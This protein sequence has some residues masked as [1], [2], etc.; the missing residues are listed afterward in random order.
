M[1][2]AKWA[3]RCLCVFFLPPRFPSFPFQELY[4]A[5]TPLKFEAVSP[6][7]PP[8]CNIFF[9]SPSISFP[10]PAPILSAIFGL[11]LKLRSA[12][13]RRRFPP[14]PLAPHVS[15]WHQF[16]ACCLFFYVFPHNCSTR[17]AYFCPL[18]NNPFWS[19]YGLDFRWSPMLRPTQQFSF[20]PFDSPHLL[21]LALY[22]LLFFPTFYAFFSGGRFPLGFPWTVVRE[23]RPVSVLFLPFWFF[24]SLV[25]DNFLF[26]LKSR[27]MTGQLSS[28]PPVSFVPTPHHSAL[29]ENVSAPLYIPLSS[30]GTY[31]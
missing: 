9:I 4:L 29:L 13:L 21:P 6:G 23:S 26:S 15:A 28:P 3:D 8:S 22:F 11:F 10:P 24:G 19:L 30:P 16:L 5:G 17:Q 2:L 12:V 1:R 20:P 14:S 25:W 18:P 7:S 27:T 31:N